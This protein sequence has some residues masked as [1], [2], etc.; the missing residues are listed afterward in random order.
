MAVQLASFMVPKNGNTF[1]LLEDKYLKGGLRLVADV[2]ERSAINPLSFK[3]GMLVITQNDKKIWQ[4]GSDLLTWSEF[5]VGGSSP[6]R[7]TVTYG[8][9]SLTPNESENFSLP[10]GRSALIYQL[11][12]DTTCKV[13]AFDSG[14][15]DET[16]PYTFI[17]TSDH[18]EDDGS[19]VMTDGT[20]LRGRRYSILTN[21]EGGTSM[22][23]YFR[24][25]NTDIVAK[26]VNLTMTFL[27]LELAQP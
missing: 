18:L 22:D 19:T 21:Q 6:V 26:N 8:T 3:A 16:N 13:E 27:P 2:A 15:R 12:V 9:K 4:L 17:S 5:K 23:V 24:I 7:Q 20:I 25:T 1:F 10:L 14:N 11:K